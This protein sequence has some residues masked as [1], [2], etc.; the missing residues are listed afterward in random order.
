MNIAD[1]P[2]DQLKEARWNPNVM[3]EAMLM[4]LRESISRFGLVSN[5]VV[6]T[7]G[8]DTYEVL[9]GNQR[10]QVLKDSNVQTAPC[11]VL[12]LDDSHARLLAQGLNRIEG[13]DDLGLKA[14]LVREVLNSIPQSEVMSLLPDSSES[15]TALVSLGE[16]D[17]AQHLQ[18]WDQAQ[19]ARLRH[20]TFQLA[21]SQLEVIGSDRAG[22]G[23][24]HR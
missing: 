11:V 4:R 20:L 17:M 16:A 8:D 15:L 12:D 1:L 5:L 2:I 9:S 18:A 21:P 14:E 6:R 24:H 10:L 13:T 23:R 22:C 3:N 7:L 19:A